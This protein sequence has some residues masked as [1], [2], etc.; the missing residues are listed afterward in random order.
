MR[1]N[2]ATRKPPRSLPHMLS[3]TSKDFPLRTATRKP[4]EVPAHRHAET[5]KDFA[6]ALLHKHPVRQTCF[7]IH[8][9]ST[10][11]QLNV[12]KRKNKKCPPTP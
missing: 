3:E 12:N 1:F 6:C 11:E 5:S 7:F 8:C 2:A 4:F 9:L 10:A